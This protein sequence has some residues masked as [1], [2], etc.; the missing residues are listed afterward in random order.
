MNKESGERNGDAFPVIIH[1][2]DENIF[3]L[4]LT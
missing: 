2:S 4:S 1:A 3:A